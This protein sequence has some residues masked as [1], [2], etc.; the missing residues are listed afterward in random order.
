MHICWP[1]CQ[2]SSSTTSLK[3][4]EQKLEQLEKEDIEEHA[5]SPTPWVSPIVEVPKHHKPNEIRICV[6]MRA[7]N[8]A[9]IRE[10]HI[11]PMIDD[12][13]HDLNGCI[14]FSK[15]I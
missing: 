14:V 10:R 2:N 7:L 6:D 11:I 3:Q 9:I 13:V 5:E 8:K 1:V 12:I 15:L 4:T